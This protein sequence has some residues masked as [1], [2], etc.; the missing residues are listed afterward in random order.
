MDMTE[1][2]NEQEAK[3]AIK[4]ALLA[5]D[6]A[7][8]PDVKDRLTESGY[9]QFVGYRSELREKLIN[10]SFP[11]VIGDVPQPEWTEPES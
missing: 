4:A 1:Y 6:Y 8:L 9:Q 3:A 2:S 5:T 7:M 10:L 11:L